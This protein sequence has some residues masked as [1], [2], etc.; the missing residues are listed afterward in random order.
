MPIIK[1]VSNE[2]GVH[3]ITLQALGKQLKEKTQQITK[4]KITFIHV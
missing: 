3:S 4:M 1:Y 2:R